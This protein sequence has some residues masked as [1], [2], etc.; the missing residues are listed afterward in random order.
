MLGL[1]PKLLPLG[2]LFFGSFSSSTTYNLNSYSVGPGGTN[3][4]ASTTYKA[5]ANVGEQTN[6]STNS[7]T[8]ITNGGAVKTEQLNVPLAPTLSNGSGTFYNKLLAT[9]NTGILPSDT[10]YA[11]AISSDNFVTT[12]YVQADGSMNTSA[13]YQTYT[14]WG[15]GSGTY[16]VGL[17]PSTS[18]EVKV[19]AKQ[20]LFT[21]TVYGPFATTATVSPSITFSLSPNS[22]SLGSLNFGT[23]ITSG[24]PVVFNLTTNASA[25]GNVYV[26]GQNGGLKSTHASYTIAALSNNLSTQSEGFGLQA[27]TATQTSGGPFTI[28]APYNGT[29]N[30][31]GTETST[32]ATIF[33]SANPI[34]GGTVNL[35]LLAKSAS[36]DPAA[37][38]YQEILTFVAAASF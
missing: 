11:L 21:N 26:S 10:T 22:V 20:G 1:I 2:L 16:I 38:D 3:N 34:V 4:A 8:Y 17:A 9:I 25:G 23:V 36:T 7:P 5:Q 29:G 33:S 37:Q 31:V 35:N 28:V 24:S 14:A 15:G 6:Q 27:N 32:Y 30:N 18:Y 13:V 12:K 19:A